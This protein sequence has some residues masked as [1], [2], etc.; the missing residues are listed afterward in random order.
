MGTT[1]TSP[2]HLENVRSVTNPLARVNSFQVSNILPG[3]FFAFH[4]V[5]PYF[6]LL[7]YLLKH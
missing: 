5:C 4:V 2:V 3:F 1:V 7:V 6:S